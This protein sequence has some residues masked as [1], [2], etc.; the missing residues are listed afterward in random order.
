MTK[1]IYLKVEYDTP[2]QLAKLDNSA[3]FCADVFLWVC[4]VKENKIISDDKYHIG[5]DGN[6]ERN[7]E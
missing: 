4:K 7:A 3:M 2:E 6:I 5:N 1:S